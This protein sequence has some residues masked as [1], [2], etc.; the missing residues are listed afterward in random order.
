MLYIIFKHVSLES[1]Y[2]VLFRQIFKYRENK[3]NNRFCEIQE[4]FLKM[5]QIIYL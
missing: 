3:S 1:E 2:I 4:S 5:K